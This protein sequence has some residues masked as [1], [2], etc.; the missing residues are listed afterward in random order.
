MRLTTCFLAFLLVPALAAPTEK[1]LFKHG[2]VADLH[3]AHKDSGIHHADHTGHA[4]ELYPRGGKLSTAR[5]DTRSAAARRLSDT[6]SASNRPRTNGRVGLKPN[7]SPGP[8]IRSRPALHTPSD[9]KVG[10]PYMSPSERASKVRTPHEPRI[11]RPIDTPASNVPIDHG[12]GGKGR[13]AF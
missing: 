7:V 3:H 9:S 5:I 2:E 13:Y 10:R 6:P 4:Q 12:I 8:R 1:N 11:R